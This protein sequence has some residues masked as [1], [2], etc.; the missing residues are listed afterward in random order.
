MKTATLSIALGLVLVLLTY[1]GP[2]VQ[3]PRSTGRLLVLNKEDSTFVAVNPAYTSQDCHQCGHRQQMP[4]SERS[5]LCPVCGLSCER[6][7]N[8]A[9]NILA[10]GLASIGS[11]SVEAPQLQPWGVVT[12]AVL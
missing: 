5:Y 6:D 2:T 10:R 3:T 9:L 7:H 8:A 12:I 1:G 4:L 11:Q